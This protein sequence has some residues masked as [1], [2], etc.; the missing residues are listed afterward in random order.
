MK[1][2]S[3]WW[4][5]NF[6]LTQYNSPQGIELGKTYLPFEVF[7][8]E[9]RIGFIG[10]YAMA[11]AD[12]ISENEIDAV[13]EALCKNFNNRKI[14]VRLPPSIY[15][16]QLV[17]ANL[18]SILK[19]GGTKLYIDLNHHLNLDLEFMNCI[20]RNRKRELVKSDS[21]GYRFQKINLGMAFEVISRNRAHKNLGISISLEKLSTLAESFPAS[22][23]FYGVFHKDEIMSASISIRINSNL[24]YIFMW[25]H[26]SSIESS[27]NSISFLARELGY[28]YKKKG[29]RFLCLGT[30]S[31]AGVQDNGLRQFKLSLGAIETTRPV[32]VLNQEEKVK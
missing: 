10:P 28:L 4:E 29:V 3:I 31:V 9:V 26:N 30:S 8:N 11:Y 20:N 16:P 17:E 19:F 13:W 6:I 2:D 5:N 25:G 27:G 14:L 12:Q 7:E 15:F 23:A 18:N 32:M 24:A 21:L 1:F 22:V